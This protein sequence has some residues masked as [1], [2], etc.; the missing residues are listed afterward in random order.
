MLLMMN[1][2]S[3]SDVVPRLRRF[4]VWTAS[5]LIDTGFLLIWVLVQWFAN[6][7]IIPRFRLSGIDAII[8]VIFQVLFATSTLVPVA[9]YIYVDVA[10]TIPQAR[11]MAKHDGNIDEKQ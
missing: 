9:A 5:S 3:L 7:L 11:R 1:E 2:T 6:E 10:A 8:L 4:L